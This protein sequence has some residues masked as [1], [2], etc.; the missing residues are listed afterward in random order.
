MLHAGDGY[1]IELQEKDRSSVRISAI[2]CH[3]GNASV[4]PDLMPFFHLDEATRAT[5]LKNVKR[6]HPDKAIIVT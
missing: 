1:I 6:R 2:W 3:P 5:V 4:E